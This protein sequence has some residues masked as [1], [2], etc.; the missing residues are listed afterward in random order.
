[1]AISLTD[2]GLTFPDGTVLTSGNFPSDKADS[3]STTTN[4]TLSGDSGWVDHLSVTFTTSTTTSVRAMAIFGPSYESGACVGMARFDLDGSQTEPV[5]VAIQFNSNKA[6]GPHGTTAGFNNVS[7]GSHTLK[8]Q[9]RNQGGGTT[10][11][12]NYHGDPD[13][14]IV[15]YK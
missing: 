8:L 2:A 5:L 9:T 12:L 3:A 13:R 15:G 6:T 7:A 14:L 4:R 1:M 11:I 10:W